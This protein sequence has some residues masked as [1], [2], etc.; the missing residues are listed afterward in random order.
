MTRIPFWFKAILTAVI[1]VLLV[2]TFAFTSCTIPSTGMENSLYPGEQAL[3]EKWAYGFRVPFFLWRWASRRAERG[4]IVLFNNPS[5]L[6]LRTMVGNRELF[7]GRCVGVPGDTLQLDSE[8]LVTDKQVLKPETQLLYA[9]PCADEETL[10]AAMEQV[11]IVGNCLVG[12]TEGKYIREFSCY[13]AHLLT[14]E[15]GERMELLPLHEETDNAIHAFVVPVKG[16][17][18]EVHP[19]NAVLLCN[20]IVRHEGKHA[21]V[22]GDTLYVEGKPVREYVFGKDYY[23]MASNNP[24]NLCDSRLFGWVPHD[25]LV[26][27]VWRIL[28]SP[29]WERL[30]QRVQ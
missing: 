9:Y 17:A 2:R 7:I 5:P 25:H 12:Y 20:T 4:D 22:E 28:F 11:G 19:W 6:S 23:W 15:L 3:V 26:G 18:V 13:D 24:V 27:K 30:F 21:S 1:V 14:Q 8:L 10:L 16:Q 29:K